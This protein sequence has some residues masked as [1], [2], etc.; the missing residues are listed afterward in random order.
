MT[1]AL[2]EIAARRQEIDDLRASQEKAIADA[3]R[4]DERLSL[5]SL[6]K[7]AGMTDEGVRQLL[8]RHGVTLRGRGG[9]RRQRPRVNVI[10]GDGSRSTEIEGE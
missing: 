9:D 3:Y 7:A 1:E 5:S 2:D 10:E 8:K 6:A 4:N